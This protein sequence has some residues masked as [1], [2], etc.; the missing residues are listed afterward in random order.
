[1]KERERG[2]KAS[3]FQ[4]TLVLSFGINFI[5][6]KHERNFQIHRAVLFLPEVK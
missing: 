4:I 6:C 2:G 1:M 5:F 3:P